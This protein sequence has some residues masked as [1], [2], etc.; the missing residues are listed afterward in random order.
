MKNNSALF[1][2]VLFF[3]GLILLGTILLCLPF[4]RTGSQLSVLT[5]LF[6]VTSAVCVTGLSVVN[7]SEYFTVSGQV[8]IMC[9]VQIGAFGYMLVSTG[10]GFILGKMALKDRKI[11]QE[12][13]DISSFNGLLKLLK[14]AIFIVLCIELIGAIVLTLN[15]SNS[16]PL[17]KA[18][19]LGIFHS[20]TAFCNAG[21]SL[22]ESSAETF[23]NSSV[24]LWTLSILILLGG[25]GFF[26]LV[27]II[28]KFYSKTKKL[29]FHSEIILWTTFCLI[30][31]GAV[32]LFLGNYNFFSNKNLGFIINNSFFQSLSFRTA[33]FNS[34]PVEI[35]S[36]PI[37]FFVMLLMFIGGGPGSTAGGLKITTLVLVF[38]FVRAL[39]KGETEYNLAKKSIDTD[40]IKKALLIFIVMVSILFLFFL[41]MLYVEQNIRPYQLIF[42]VV[43]AFCTVGLSLG[44]TSQ[45]TDLGRVVLILAMFMGRIGAVTILIYLVSTKTNKN[46]I[47]YPDGKLMIG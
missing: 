38:V 39:L 32:V 1:P 25:L 13:F 18:V 30:V 37:A 6:T 34:I 41:V 22:F 46:N 10:L 17:T 23:S 45:L 21:F 33:G 4:S 15:F 16:Y 28:D 24:T 20:I 43:S 35:I 47:R 7:I 40:L 14:K 9:L 11:M 31:I 8:I 26:V 2:I 44:V 42:E 29:T 36:A 27:D 3:I 5:C 12:L 19:F